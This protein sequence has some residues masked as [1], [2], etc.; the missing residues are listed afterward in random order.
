MTLRGSQEPRVRVEPAR[1]RTDGIDAAELYAA[2]ASPLE[3]WQELVLD[4]WLGTDEAGNYTTT[5][6][7]ASLPRQNG[8]NVDIEAR[9]LYGMVILGEKILHTA[10][11]VR[12]AKS[13]FRRM[14]Q[15]FTDRRHPEITELVRHIRMTNGE[16][17][18]ELKNGGS[19]Q[20]SARSRQAARGF[21]GIALVVF[22]EAQELTDDQLD[23]LLPTLSASATGSRQ[24]IYAGTPPYPGCPGTV[25][26]R[27]R[28]ETLKNP[29]RHEAWHEWSVE[30]KNV[31]AINVADRNLWAMCNPALGLHLTE[32]F[33]ETELRNL[34]PD[35]FARE[36]L[37]W[38][39]PEE[40]HEIERAIAAPLWDGCASNA[41]KPEGKTAFGVKFA[42]DGSVA[43]L[44]GAVIGQ[45]GKARVSLIDIRPAASGTAW[46]ADFLKKRYSTIACAAIDG[47]NG[48]DVLTDRLTSTFRAKGS[49]LRPSARDVVAAASTLMEELTEKTMTWY[50]PQTPLRESALSA[51]K[52][53]ISGG[54]GFGGDNSAPI[55]AAAL[56][57]WA[58]R[59]TKRD[60]DKKMRIG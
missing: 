12:T 45:D 47:R 26:R 19:I 23:A 27:I 14:L 35:G 58:V 31:E 60:P 48:A 11:Q 20:Y 7:G 56:A 33:T 5:S 34:S 21:E 29:G 41:K 28:T 43:A 52:R 39:A 16:E 51:V 49:L 8:K 32:D 18:I 10:H 17:S 37:G 9:E 59:T 2:Y 15:I 46:L 22:D 30:A 44:C 54:W 38:W 55:E 36:R 4:C 57:L 50:R 3:P 13:A 24:F 40:V 42:A 25:F 53:P 1:V 6:A